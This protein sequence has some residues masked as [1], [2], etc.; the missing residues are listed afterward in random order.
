MCSRG[1]IRLSAF[2]AE[3]RAS[4]QVARNTVNGKLR[5]VITQ[6]NPSSERPVACAIAVAA[7]RPLDREAGGLIGD[8]FELAPA[9]QR[10]YF[11]S[12]ANVRSRAEACDRTSSFSSSA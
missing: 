3:M 10:I 4:Y 9:I 7:L 8:V 2:A 12:V 11:L 1:A 6:E 5:G